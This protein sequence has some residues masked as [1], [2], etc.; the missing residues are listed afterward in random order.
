MGAD[1]AYC[2]NDASPEGEEL[3]PAEE[4]QLDEI[5][6]GPAVADAN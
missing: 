4:G 2:L 5:E 1:A 6:H 3:T